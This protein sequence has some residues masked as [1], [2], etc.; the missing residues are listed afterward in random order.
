ML[1][2]NCGISVGDQAIL[3]SAC[4]TARRQSEAEASINATVPNAR[5]SHHSVSLLLIGSGGI[6]LILLLIVLLVSARPSGIPL[7]PM[8][9]SELD[10]FYNRC[11]SV[12]HGGLSMSKEIER[13]TG[14]SFGG[15]VADAYSA[16]GVPES[17]C[18][19]MKSIC[20]ERFDSSECLQQRQVTS[21][22]FVVQQV[23]HGQ[24]FNS[25]G[26]PECRALFEICVGGRVFTPQCAALMR[27]HGVE[28]PGVR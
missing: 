3:C 5:R 13:Q 4:A 17:Q 14:G 9:K 8:Q 19:D 2:P 24:G 22:F 23:C 10:S 12:F 26:T 16:L 1:C 27:R 11:V 18:D 28:M 6:L 20:T 25:M 15:V 21:L 7:T